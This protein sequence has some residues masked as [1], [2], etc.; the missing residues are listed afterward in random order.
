MWDREFDKASWNGTPINL[1]KTSIERGKRVNVQHMPYSDEPFVEVMGEESRGYKFDAV[2]VGKDSLGQAS[3]FIAALS[4]EP[5]GTLEHPYLG[6]LAL[7]Y[8]KSSQSFS[9]KKGEV[10]LS[11]EFVMQGLPITLPAVYSKSVSSL[12]DA[13]DEWAM[14]DFSEAMKA[15]PIDQLNAV[16]QKLD[17]FVGKL[18]K[19]SGQLQLPITLVGQIQTKI[20]SAL[21]A[22]TSVANAPRTFATGLIA[23]VSGLVGAIASTGT[24]IGFAVTGN[25][26]KAS[27]EL[28][29]TFGATDSGSASTP[30]DRLIKALSVSSMLRLSA[31]LS[32]V[33]DS[34]DGKTLIATIEPLGGL[35]AAKAAIAQLSITVDM[36]I[37]DATRSA[38]SDTMP[39]VDAL[40]A[41][42]TELNTQL[43]K[44]ND[45]YI[46]TAIV[47]VVVST[48]ALAL[49]YRHS[50]DVET[51]NA[52]NVI[53]HPLFV[54]G[55]VL[56]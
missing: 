13:V 43:R 41:V 17:G 24:G 55:E 16:K 46:Q 19:L 40:L 32:L 28:M 39:L 45:A 12:T 29:A 18:N 25:A 38:S 51:L 23:A 42:K 22:L 20:Q 53:E 14:F 27:R 9:T 49:A 50:V 1:L 6:E 10:V 52:L 54:K 47:P 7:V 5:E 35:Y 44:I 34:H 37:S 8:Q 15:L 31:P 11:I 33:M 2:F 4:S 36:L 56:L 3:A 30:A 26:P 48:P 21:G